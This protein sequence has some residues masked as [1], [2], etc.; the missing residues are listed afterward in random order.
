[1]S[2]AQAGTDSPR[3]AARHATSATAGSVANGGALREIDT[4]LL[5]L[6]GVSSEAPPQTDEAC[7]V[8]ATLPRPPGRAVARADRAKAVYRTNTGEDKPRPYDVRAN[9]TCP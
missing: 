3:A 8:G 7:L 9:A 6:E 1:M 4:V 2:W 5:R